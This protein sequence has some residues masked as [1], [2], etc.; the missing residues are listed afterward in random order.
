MC[1]ARLT[2]NKYHVI[3][4][5]NGL[6]LAIGSECVDHMLNN[7][8]LVYGN[9]NDSPEEYI[10]RQNLYEEYPILRQIVD[11]NSYES[12][13]QYTLSIQIERKINK[14]SRDTKNLINNYVCNKTSLK[15]P[16]IKQIVRKS[17]ALRGDIKAFNLQ[18]SLDKNNYLTIN[19]ESEVSKTKNKLIIRKIQKNE[20]KLNNDI[21][22]KISTPTFIKRVIGKNKTH[23][24]FASFTINGTID[25]SFIIKNQS[26][27][28]RYK[29][30]DFVERFGFNPPFSKNT[31]SNQQ[32]LDELSEYTPLDFLDRETKMNL[33]KNVLSLLNSF[34][35]YSPDLKQV[36]KFVASQE[37][38]MNEKTKITKHN[39]TAVTSNML[40]LVNT[41]QNYIKLDLKK[42][43]IIGLRTLYSNSQDSEI[44]QEVLYNSKHYENKQ[45]VFMEI[46]DTIVLKESSKF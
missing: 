45:K 16:M 15:Q 40:F 10:K 14:F 2:A 31:F 46:Y 22:Q 29:F 42:L 1:N 25:I 17:K 34:S 23:S 39:L 35:V 13:A 33:N 30:G 32:V 5:E 19:E 43:P 24:P 27:N 28:I 12:E 38:K 4:K 26:Y 6:E 37:A 21:A 7:S 18:A 3:N 9:H 20:G 11:T 8:E 41:S 36:K 44:R